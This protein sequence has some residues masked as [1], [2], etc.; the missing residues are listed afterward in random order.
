MAQARM[1]S[2]VRKIRT[3][4]GFTPREKKNGGAKFRQIINQLDGF[5]IVQFIFAKTASIGSSIAMDTGKVTPL[6]AA[7]E[8]VGW[9]LESDAFPS[10]HTRPLRF[11]RGCPPGGSSHG[12][13]RC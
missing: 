2:Q 4:Q 6:C 8:A 7:N 10:G 13:R 1:F 12:R 5:I 11:P 9:V 3:N